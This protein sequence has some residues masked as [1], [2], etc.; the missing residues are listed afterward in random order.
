MHQ[1]N[2]PVAFFQKVSGMT[3]SR[4]IDELTEGGF[5]EY[6]YEFPREFSYSHIKFEIGL[7]SSDF[8][9][10][11]MM[12]G[13]EQGFA[14]G[15]NF[16]LLQRYPDKPYDEPRIWHFDSA[17]PV[18]WQI[19]DLSIGNSKSIVIEKLELSFNTFTPPL[20]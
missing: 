15:I 20:P 18:K 13:K 5:N 8:F 7:S 1:L 3:V 4:N 17:F 2:K 16:D 9:Y 11:W 12:Y 19:S 10:K 14:K 6:T